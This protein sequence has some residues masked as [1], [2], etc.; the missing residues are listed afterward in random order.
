MWE[1]IVL[2]L[3]S[4]A[5]KFTLEGRIT[6]TLRAEG[7]AIRLRVADTGTGIPADE[8]P[9][10][11]ERFHRVEGARGRTHEGTGIGLALVQELARLHGGRVEVESVFGDGTTFTV[12]IPTGTRPLA[13][14]PDRGHAARSPRRPWGRRPTSRRRS[15]GCPTRRSRRRH[16]PDS[17]DHAGLSRHDAPGTPGR[18]GER[19]RILLADDNADMRE[20]VC[21]LLAERYDVTAVADGMQALAAARAS[22]P[23]WSSPT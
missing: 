5:F 6:V 10:L 17:E 20:Y 19:P 7:D 14:R 13:G 22:R 4:N 8:L 9:H 1:K 18:G 21:R 11:F 23:T 15:A 16:A 2:N 12:T 3:L